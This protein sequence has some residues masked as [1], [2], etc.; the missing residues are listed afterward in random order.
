MKYFVTK[1]HLTGVLKGIKTSENTNVKFV[2]N[3]V[4]KSVTGFKYK[5]VKIEYC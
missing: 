2:V 1:E 4:Y 3:K 5:I